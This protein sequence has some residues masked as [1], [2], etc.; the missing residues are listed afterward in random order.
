MQLMQ[1]FQA[2]Q[3]SYSVSDIKQ[4]KQNTN[5]LTQMFIIII[6]YGF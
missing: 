6:T 2:T 3:K 4:N 5:I 1:L